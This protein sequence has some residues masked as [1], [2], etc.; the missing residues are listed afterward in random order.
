M[1]TLLCKHM[2]PQRIVP[3]VAIPFL[4]SIAKYKLY[5]TGS[6]AHHLRPGPADAV[7]VA[8]V[9]LPL[10]FFYDIFWVFIQPYLTHGD[11]VM[12]KVL[13]HPLSAWLVCS[14]TLYAQCCKH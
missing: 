4:L 9:L 3:F 1:S 2:S 12:V 10:S 5:Q 7:Q 11:S 6:L 8:C 14:L 13:S